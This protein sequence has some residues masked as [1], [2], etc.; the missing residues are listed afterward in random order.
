MQVS[1]VHLSGSVSLWLNWKLLSPTAPAPLHL[2]SYISLQ[3]EETAS[4]TVEVGTRDCNHP[5]SGR[6]PGI[7]ERNNR[8]RPV[9]VQLGGD[10]SAVETRELA[11]L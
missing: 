8:F 3:E 10:V 9:G 2:C 7:A 4:G 11:G 1:T 5:H 6:H